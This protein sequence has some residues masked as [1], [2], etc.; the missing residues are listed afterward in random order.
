MKKI[1]LYLCLTM[2]WVSNTQAVKVSVK[3]VDGAPL[4][5]V[6]VTRSWAN[7]PVQDLSDD[8]YAPNGKTNSSPEEMTRFTDAQGRTEFGETLAAKKVNYRLRKMGYADLTFQQ[9]AVGQPISAVMKKLTDIESLAMQKPAN[10]WLSQLDFG[11][12]D[13]LKKHFQLNCA[14]CHQQGS[15]FMRVERSKEQWRTIIDRMVGYGARVADDLREPMAEHL[16]KGYRRLRE[17]VE[18]IPSPRPWQ[19]SLNSAKISEW[20]IGDSFSQMH[21][22]LLHPNGFIYVGDNVQD[23]IYEVNPKNGQFTV[24][25]VPH[26]PDDRP[27]GLLGNRFSLHGKINSYTGVHSFAVSP[28]DGH[29][30]ITPSLQQAIIEFD[31]INK[32]FTRH[33]MEE[34]LYPHTIRVD[35]QDRVWFTLAISSQIAMFDR[36]Q[37]AFTLYDLPSRSIKD[38]LIT[39]LV[40]WVMKLEPE[41][42]PQ[43]SIDK[44]NSGLPQPYGI[45][46][47]ADGRVWFTRLYGNDIGVIDPKDG[48]VTMIETP[49]NGPRR[50]RIDN[51][52]NIWIVAFQDSRLMKYDPVAK[53][54]TNYELPVLNETPYALNID[55]ERGLVWVNGNQ[56]D[57]LL[58]FNIANESWNVYPMPKA[59]T[60]TRDIEIDTDGS[61]YTSNSQFPSWQIEGGQP[62][63]IR[64]Q[65]DNPVQEVTQVN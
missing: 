59:R 63:L 5:T 15:E 34:G 60:F 10:T 48:S 7:M 50:L 41:N 28:T 29:I 4:A 44:D 3:A 61:V 21:D 9:I 54:F 58:S 33:E 32:T 12:D 43:P 39:K 38:W 51:S 31:P 1:L 57:T 24:Y 36:S 45:D 13:S 42:R 14:F 2:A 6:M 62:T 52:G 64:V 23:R 35:A 16:S 49:F 30:F 27:G 55:K 40:P 8:G 11:S 56:S 17:N 47:A 65:P 37:K 22:L 25:K 26:Q 20:P 19:P 46:V 53:R 18:Q